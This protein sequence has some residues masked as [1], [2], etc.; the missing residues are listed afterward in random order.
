VEAIAADLDAVGA[1]RTA[2]QRL[3]SMDLKKYVTDTVG[4][5]SYAILSVSSRSQEEIHELSLSMQLS[6]RGRR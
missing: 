4:E 5:P 2:A 1:D 6:K 3:K